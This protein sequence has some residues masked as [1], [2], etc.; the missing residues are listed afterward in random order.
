MHILDFCRC[1]CTKLNCFIS[2]MK[3]VNFIQK[4][5]GSPQH[6][7]LCCR[8]SLPPLSRSTPWPRCPECE[9]SK[10]LERT[11]ETHIS[12][13]KWPIWSSLAYLCCFIPLRVV[14]N[15]ERN[16]KSLYVFKSQRILWPRLLQV[17]IFYSVVVP[18]IQSFVIL[19]FMSHKYHSRT[20]R[21]FR[22]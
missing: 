1:L 17:Q 19:T 16:P 14:K 10:Q 5:N 15:Q 6:C 12:W 22:M 4:S 8:C 20:R 7:R 18:F 11:Y 3:F 2:I 21:N 9:E 13:G